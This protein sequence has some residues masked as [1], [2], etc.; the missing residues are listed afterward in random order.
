MRN[1]KKVG[2]R[3][4]G[5]E[6]IYHCPNCPPK[7][8]S[9]ARLEV[10]QRTGLGHCFRCG[11]SF[12][13]KELTKTKDK[14]QW[15]QYNESL[16][17]VQAVPDN[18]ERVFIERGMDFRYTVSRY[19]IGWD[20][21]RLCWTVDDGYWRR[22]V[23]SWDEP[24]V[25]FDKGSHGVLGEHLFGNNEILVLTEGDWKAAAVPLPWIGG[26]LGGTSISNYQLNVI[27]WHTPRLVVVALDGG[28]DPGKVLSSLHKN[29][30]EAVPWTLPEGK[31]PDDIP[32]TER[33]EG[34]LEVT[35]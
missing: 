7:K 13:V 30:I 20:G 32:M 14:V 19:R 5:E 25:R 10:N 15:P 34:L 28:V 9:E 18:L 24:K 4:G 33:V 8:K 12:K 35:T 22:A 2:E 17:E 6:F 23:Y 21:R 29:L 11:L 16:P 3:R 31:G 27:K 1:L 26:G